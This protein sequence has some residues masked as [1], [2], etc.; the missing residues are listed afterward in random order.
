MKLSK[1]VE[2]IGEWDRGPSD[3]EIN[4]ICYD[5]RQVA[6][7]D[8]YV[9]L[10]GAKLDGHDFISS[11]C[12]RGAAAVVH[13]RDCELPAG[14]IGV[15]VP[16]SREALSKLATRFYHDPSARLTVIGV[17]GTKGKTTT[18]YLIEHIL[19]ECGI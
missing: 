3:P 1:L 13:S 14:V 8:M 5:S 4:K 12:E 19:N 2:G 17:T 7:G 9:A 10:I 16:D 15:R 18:T 6:K 11:A